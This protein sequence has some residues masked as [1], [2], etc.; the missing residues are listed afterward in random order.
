MQDT[1]DINQLIQKS[2]FEVE[3]I[4]ERFRS[5]ASIRGVL[6]WKMVQTSDSLL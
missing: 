1:S 4:P 5:S 3:E 2:R 6:G